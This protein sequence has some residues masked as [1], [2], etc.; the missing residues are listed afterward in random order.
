MNI[1][2][3]TQP[4]CNNYGGI[5]Q[6]FALQTVLER[7]GHNVITLNYPINNRYSGN[8]IRHLLSIGKRTIKK[9]YGE[10]GIIWVDIAKESRMQIKLAHLQKA[11]LDK[12]LHLQNITPPITKEQVSNL[13]I[14]TFIVGSDQTWRPR[15][16][17]YL[18]NL[19]LD[20][21]EDMGVKR[22][23]YAASFGTD[24]WEYSPEQTDRCSQL[25][26]KFDAISVREASGIDLCRN[27]LGVDAVQMLDPTLLLSAD[28]YLSLCSEH[29]YTE[30]DYIAVY[31]LDYT[32]EKL[33]LLNDISKKLNTPL[34]F[35]G[36]FTKQG[37]PSVESWIE[38]I[39][40]A[41]Y[42]I[43]DSFHGTVFSM[44]FER[45]FVS[46]G[47][48]TRGNSRFD[49]LF[50]TFNIPKERLTNNVGEIVQ[51]LQ[52]NIDYDSVNMVKSEWQE[53][54]SQFLKKALNN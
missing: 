46:L 29:E 15:Y 40:H 53:D 36:R 28:E 38:G 11:F 47:N 16:N 20:F 43:T 13:N 6:N 48:S 41:K 51:S 10:P 42:V 8:I 31:T 17:K 39:A 33:T 54:S 5:L 7:M 4:I 50:K 2:I 49:S 22:I 3:L 18:E 32:K 34:H 14:D 19:F 37:Y 9:I 27:N 24:K 21:T 1:A 25:A 45:Q 35:I 26:N 12:Y 52:T 23:A 30:G 44:I